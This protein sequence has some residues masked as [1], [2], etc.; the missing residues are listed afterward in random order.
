MRRRFLTSA[1]VVMTF[2]SVTPAFAMSSESVGK[3]GNIAEIAATSARENVNV[4]DAIA[5]AQKVKPFV[6]Y[7]NGKPVLTTRDAK[8][9][10]ISEKDLKDIEE[11]MNFFLI[12]CY[13]YSRWNS[14]QTG[15]R[16]C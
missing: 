16:V 5:L 15:G 13:N 12:S 7:V 2:A 8:K 3:S 1:V 9:I 14:S 11:G 4:Q 10:G 6:T